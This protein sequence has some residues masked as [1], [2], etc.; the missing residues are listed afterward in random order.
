MSRI[1][2]FLFTVMVIAG[3]ATVSLAQDE[4][5]MP[6]P[7]TKAGSAAWMFTVNGLGDFGLN[8]F[9]LGPNGFPVVGAG[10]KWYFSDDMAIRAMLGLA[11]N[12]S[13]DADVTKSTNGKNSTTAFGLAVAVEM[14]THTVYSTSPYF[15]A[16]LMF[17]SGSTTNTK[18]V[19]NTST[20]T[21]SSA[22]LFGIGAL[23]GF[24]WYFTRGLAVGAEYMLGFSSASASSTSAGT[25]TDAPSS[26][27]IGINYGGNVHL[28]VH[29]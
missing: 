8:G 13:G 26:T 11:T 1:S 14:H 27:S 24:D 20:E 5:N 28:V 15:G 21:K 7:N 12:S 25:T 4:A 16:Q 6:K 23:A 19:S 3:F 2:K 17:S 9:G 22:G 10:W 18:T 29:F